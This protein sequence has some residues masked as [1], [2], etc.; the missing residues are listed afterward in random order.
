MNPF[1]FADSS[2]TRPN[3][4]H[5]PYLLMWMT[6]SLF[7][8]PYTVDKLICRLAAY[9]PCQWWLYKSFTGPSLEYSSLAWNPQGEIEALERFPFEYDLIHFHLCT[10]GELNYAS[11][12]YT[13][14][15]A[16][17]PLHC[18]PGNLVKLI[19]LFYSPN[20][21]TLNY[22]LYLM[23]SQFGIVTGI[24]SVCCLTFCF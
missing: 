17:F 23:Q 9:S 1:I 6:E 11:I 22:T 5:T 21:S 14:S 3:S 20:L 12:I 2:L 8:I 16:I 10:R 15:C 19:D 24:F 7:G 4:L 18:L 13:K